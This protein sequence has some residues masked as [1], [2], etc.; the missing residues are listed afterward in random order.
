MSDMVPCPHCGT[1]L[2]GFECPTC[3]I[4]F[5]VSPSLVASRLER[6]ERS[7]RRCIHCDLPLSYSSVLTP[8][9]ADG[10]NRDAYITCADC[11]CQ[12]ILEDF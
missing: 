9:W 1:P 11:G 10:D 6:P 5:V 3:E 2:T 8:A 12:N 4:E 7:E